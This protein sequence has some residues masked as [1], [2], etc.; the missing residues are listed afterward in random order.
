MNELNK[1]R[2]EWYR[3]LA[4]YVVAAAAKRARDPRPHAEARAAYEAAYEAE[5]GMRPA[6][7]GPAEMAVQ[8]ESW[9]FWFGSAEGAEAA[10]ILR[11]VARGHPAIY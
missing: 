7:S 10:D 1:A 5:Y 8:L 11:R 6:P 3:A 9:D 4:T 2:S